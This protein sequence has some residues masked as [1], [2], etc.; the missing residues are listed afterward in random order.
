MA[1]TKKNKVNCNPAI[2]NKSLKNTCY[3]KKSLLLIN[4]GV[5]FLSA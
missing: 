5:N 4:F 3:D 1:K 2:K